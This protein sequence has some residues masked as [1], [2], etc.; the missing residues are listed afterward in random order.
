MS[1]VM[2]ALEI[3]L[4]CQQNRLMHNSWNELHSL[5]MYLQKYNQWTQKAVYD[6]F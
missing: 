4:N 2:V 6:K 5:Y 1:T 3:W